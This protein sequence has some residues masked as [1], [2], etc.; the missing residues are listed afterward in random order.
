MELNAT[1][2]GL[3]S[4]QLLS[5]TL[6]GPRLSLETTVPPDTFFSEYQGRITVSGLSSEKAFYLAM[7]SERTPPPRL[8][9]ALLR[10][11]KR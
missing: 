6:D 4:D 5:A 1:V 8:Q 3:T 7:K 2:L 11:L 10:I 9:M